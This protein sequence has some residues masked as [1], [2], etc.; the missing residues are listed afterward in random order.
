MDIWLKTGSSKK[1]ENSKQD[2]L[3]DSRETDGAASVNISKT[4]YGISV[5]IMT[6]I[7]YSDMLVNTVGQLVLCHQTLGKIYM[8][9]AKL[10]HHSHTKYVDY[11]NKLVAFVKHNCDELKHFQSDQT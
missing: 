8:V 1:C 6:I 5:N 10:H 3:H 7:S 11:T 4:N 9:A 2:Q